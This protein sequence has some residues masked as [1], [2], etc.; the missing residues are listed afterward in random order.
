M[1]TYWRLNSIRLTVKAGM[2]V[3]HVAV[4]LPCLYL[5]L[6]LLL[7]LPLLQEHQ[8]ATVKPKRFEPNPRKRRKHP[9]ESLIFPDNAGLEK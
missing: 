5:L 1:V 7:L 4:F 2:N 3:G 8:K 9:K 6:L